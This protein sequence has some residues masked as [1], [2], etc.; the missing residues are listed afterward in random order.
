[1]SGRA[2]L[3]ACLGVAAA[4]VLIPATFG[5]DGVARG[6]QLGPGFWPRLILVGLALA[7]AGRAAVAWRSRTRRASTGRLAEAP[8]PIA[9]PTL[10]AAVALI[11]L[12][13]LAPPAVGFPVATAVFVAV[14]MWLAGSRSAVTLAGCALG[15]TVVLLYIFVKVVYLPL[16]KGAGPF[17]HLTLALYRA[18]GIF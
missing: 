12:Y 15:G 2:E 4:V 11:V 14:F 8:S 5:L 3:G 18:L 1:M 6:G 16:P 7:C 9:V 10:V 13:V 17:E